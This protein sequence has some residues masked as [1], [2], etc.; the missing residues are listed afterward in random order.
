MSKSI[1]DLPEQHAEPVSVQLAGQPLW[2]AN[3]EDAAS[4][5]LAP[6]HLKGQAGLRAERHDLVGAV[7]PN[8][9]TV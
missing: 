7:L 8:V 2:L 5:Q 6:A 9:K 3:L 4:G 1:L